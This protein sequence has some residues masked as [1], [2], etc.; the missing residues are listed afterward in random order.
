MSTS[1]RFRPRQGESKVE[2][3]SAQ[4]WQTAIDTWVRT[5][6]GLYARFTTHIAVIVVAIL[7]FSANLPN[8]PFEYNLAP[9]AIP[10]TAPMLGFRGDQDVLSG[11]GG[12]REYTTQ[13]TI[14]NTQVIAKVP[15]APVPVRLQSLKTADL[16]RAPVVHTTIP[17]RLRRDVITYVVQK[18]DNLL[19]IA[20][21]FDLEQETIM[22]ANASVEQNP[23]LLRPGQELVILPIDGIYHTVAKGETIE[24]I[25]KKY[26]AS[27]QDIIDCPYNQLDPE[28][29]QIAPEDKLIV[30][31]GVKPYI[32]RQVTA[33]SGPIP[34][35]AERGTGIF[36]W[37]ASGKLT[38]RF[39]FRT[40]SGRWHSGLDISGYRG[41]PV[42]AADSGF[43][44]FAGWSDSGY[45]NL[46][47]IDHQN[48]FETRYAHL[49]AFL[50]T[51]GQSVSK[52][53]QIALM[54]TTGNSTGPHLHFEVREKGVRK[55][56]E[57][58]LP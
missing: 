35:N 19:K 37:P 41:A 5:V 56:P 46:V 36:A 38:D 53:T 17:N 24:K 39:G 32:P 25:A 23:D 50:V 15:S 8:L 40:F 9:R 42:Y 26:Q 6:R 48:G 49:N 14:T 45:G 34:A 52:G 55:N 57:L 18:G 20:G 12:P 11:R 16:L 27:V 54:G 4:R 29:P 10:T 7:V 1:L 58:Y 3:S 22:W 30:P 44:V 43:V 13:S 33:Y 31:G 21:Q 2:S 51:A 28:N 47:I